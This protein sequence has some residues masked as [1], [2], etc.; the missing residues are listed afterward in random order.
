MLNY[1]K[2][3]CAGGALVFAAG[4]PAQGGIRLIIWNYEPIYRNEISQHFGIGYDQDLNDRLSL[5]LQGRIGTDGDTWAINYRSAYHMAENTS[6]SAYFGPIV[7]FRH[8]KELE[9]NIYPVGLRFGVRGGLERF[10]ADLH[11]GVQYNVGAGSVS[12][13][14]GRYTTGLATAT[15]CIGLDRGWGWDKPGRR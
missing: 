15:Y 6:G 3:I 14:D 7:G 11:A 2:A 13:G 1:V 4:C 8:F 9:K 10:Y 5:G 12:I